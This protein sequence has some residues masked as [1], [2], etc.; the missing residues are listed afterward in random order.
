[1]NMKVLIDHYSRTPKQ[2]VMNC[3]NCFKII[4]IDTLGDFIMFDHLIV[5]QRDNV[6]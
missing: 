4:N 1:M 5:L 3:A 6:S 2:H